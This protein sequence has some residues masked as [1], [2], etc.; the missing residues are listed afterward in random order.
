VLYVGVVASETVNGALLHYEERGSGPPLLL[1]H[2][3]G[4]YADIWSPVLDG[5]ARSYR[6]IAYDR[7]GF[8]RSSPAPD[9]GLAEHARDAAALLNALD[10]SPATIVGW[11][12]GGVIALDLAAS[13]PDRVA[14][15]VLAEPAVHLTTHPSR[16]AV[17]MSVR[18][19][20]HRYV[21]RDPAAAALSM[22]RWAG[23][24][25]TGGNAY[26]PLPEA[27]REQMLA[28]A[29]A[30]L[31]EMDQMIRPYPTRAAIRSIACPVTVIEGDLS[32]PAFAR[33]V[34]FVLRLLPHA[35]LVS[36]PGAA[37]MLH[38]DQ[39]ES[40]VEIVT[41]TTGDPLSPTAASDQDPR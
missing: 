36:L 27:W 21:R 20:F 32:D 29:P 30:T 11:S 7:R 24:Y 33:A 10:A 28:H 9:G 6:V 13:F 23:G 14:A 5:L 12:G 31:H 17:A 16:D 26:D 22:Y 8:A 1:V 38:I 35:R 19:G 4:T 15:L 25:K 3:T 2:G 34:G 37:H 39:P 41:Q 18:S 40:W